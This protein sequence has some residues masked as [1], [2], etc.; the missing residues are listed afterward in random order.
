[1]KGIYEKYIQG[2]RVL[3]LNPP[4][5]LISRNIVNGP[6]SNNLFLVGTWV[7]VCIQ[8]PSHHF[9]QTFRPRR[10]F[11]IVFRDS[12]LYPKQSRLYCLLRLISASADY[13]INICSM[14]KLCTN[15]KTAIF[16]IKGF[17][18]LIMSQQGKRK[19]KS[20]L[21]FYT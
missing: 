11:K 8:K 21:D 4:L 12:S 17:G 18:H 2:G 7:I 13:I 9:L 15:S 19:I 20:L 16:N 6:R 14:I 10:M 1:M 5:S 3:G